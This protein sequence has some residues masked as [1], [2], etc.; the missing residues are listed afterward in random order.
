MK[1][2]LRSCAALALVGAM[3]LSGGLNATAA[4][5]PDLKKLNHY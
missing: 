1:K 2:F 3:I 4:K 5:K